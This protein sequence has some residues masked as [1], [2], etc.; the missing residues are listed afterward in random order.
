MKLRRRRSAAE[1]EAWDDVP[2]AEPEPDTIDS[3]DETGWQT[4]TA[5]LSG[6]AR[7]ARIGAWVLIAAGPLLGVAALLGTSAPAQSAPAAAPAAQSVADTGP[8]GFAQ[9]YVAAYI[10]AGQGTENSLSP[11]FAGSITLTNQP[12]TRSTTRT[13]AV[14]SH[15]VQPGYWT[16]TVAARVAQKDAKGA[17]SDVGLQYY[18]VP[19]QVLG[20]LSAGGSKKSDDAAA[21]YAATALPAQVAAPGALKPS[22]LG[23][24]TDRGSNPADPATQTIAG[25]LGAYLAGKG[26]L[27][28]YTSPGVTL[29]AIAPAPYAGV[30][31]TGV[32][33]DS[34][35]AS[36]TTVPTDGA[37]RQALA[38]VNAKDASG[39]TYPLTYALTLR[40]RGGRWE[41]ASLGSA[42]VLQRGGAPELVSPSPNSGGTDDTGASSSPSPSPSSS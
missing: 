16:V 6:A 23:Y 32:A 37:V 35:N 24:G 7:L 30:E 12:G 40:S 10:E 42:P 41:V 33:D 25:F 15:E 39:A 9:L 21:G 18:Q 2:A 3:E 19:V 22:G 34:G 11:Y 13:V 20:P 5:G 28:R 17:W 29:R 36:S 14:A 26:E 1:D 31:I 4:S 27:D 8:S 38:T